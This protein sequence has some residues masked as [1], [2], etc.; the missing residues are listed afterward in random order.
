LDELA[1][2]FARAIPMP[3]GPSSGSSERTLRSA[4]PI[5]LAVALLLFGFPAVAGQTRAAGGYAVVRIFIGASDGSRCDCDLAGVGAGVCLGV[6]RPA[7]Q[8]LPSPINCSVTPT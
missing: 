7:I 3:S 6:G 2:A 5:G 8:L 4:V 1:G